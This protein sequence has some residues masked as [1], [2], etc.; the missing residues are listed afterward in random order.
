MPSDRV[1]PDAFGISTRHRLRLVGAFKQ[2]NP[3]RGP[4]L[5]Q[6]RSQGI[7]AHTVDTGGSLVA[8]HMR[9]RLPQIVSLDNRFHRRPTGRLAFGFGSRRPG[10]GPFHAAASG[11]TR[12]RRLQGD[13]Q[14]SFLPHRPSEI[15]VLLAVPSFRPSPGRPAYYAFC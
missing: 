10:F 12:C 5:F 2:L 1:P 14:F 7:E 15:A 9:Q 3:D 11:F 13:L 4:V 6:V 8:F